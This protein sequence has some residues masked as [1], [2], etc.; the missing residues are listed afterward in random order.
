MQ[1]F[2][3][4]I[5]FVSLLAGCSSVQL[6]LNVSVQDVIER[7][8]SKS[9]IRINQPVE[10]TFNCIKLALLSKRLRTDYVRMGDEE[11]LWQVGS[12]SFLDQT[13]IN[14]VYLVD[15]DSVMNIYVTQNMFLIQKQLQSIGENCASDSTWTP[16]S[17][18]W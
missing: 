11:V 8:E 16:S 10:E 5:L 6:G 12:P 2:L 17:A 15:G 4:T 1:R 9:E 3:A 14:A 13:S 18:F 7:T